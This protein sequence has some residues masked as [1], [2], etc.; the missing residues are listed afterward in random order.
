MLV[1]KQHLQ[2]YGV[3]L[4]FVLCRGRSWTGGSLWVP[5]NSGYSV[6]LW[7]IMSSSIQQGKDPS[8]GGHTKCM[9]ISLASGYFSMHVALTY[10]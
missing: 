6:I 2:T 9:S 3:I 1:I 5:Y 8:L 4:G 7:S 10:R